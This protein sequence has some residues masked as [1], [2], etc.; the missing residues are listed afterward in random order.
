MTR[1]IGI[2]PVY[3]RV[4]SAGVGFDLEVLELVDGEVVVRINWHGRFNVSRDRIGHVTKRPVNPTIVRNWSGDPHEKIVKV[5]LNKALEVC[6][7]EGID[8]EMDTLETMEM[9]HLA[10]GDVRDQEAD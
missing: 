6:G 3:R 8:L 2:V 9:S 10:Q 5:A 4:N 1:I 7:E